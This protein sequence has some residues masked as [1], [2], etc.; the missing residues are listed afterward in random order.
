MGSNSYPE[1]SV[2]EGI[3]VATAAPPQGIHFDSFWALP[4][5]QIP[6]FQTTM[7]GKESKRMAAAVRRT[8]FN[9]P[10]E[11]MTDALYMSAT[12]ERE[13]RNS[14]GLSLAQGFVSL[15]KRSQQRAY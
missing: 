11:P 4:G 14:Q 2:T 9:L 7:N 10:Q 6:G 3:L 13:S 5:F 12:Q 8:W 15:L 1:S